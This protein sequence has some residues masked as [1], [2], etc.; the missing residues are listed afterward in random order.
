MGSAGRCPSSTPKKLLSSLF[1]SVL[2]HKV[3]RQ[4]LSTSGKGL[5]E[6]PSKRILESKPQPSLFHPLLNRPQQLAAFLREFAPQ[7]VVNGKVQSH[8]ALLPVLL[9][10]GHWWQVPVKLDY[11]VIVLLVG[12]A[13]AVVKL[14]LHRT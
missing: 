3:T 14:F 6:N 8:A 9:L 12:K 11:P 1:V 7:S 13:R 2:I 10:R 5:C 4:A